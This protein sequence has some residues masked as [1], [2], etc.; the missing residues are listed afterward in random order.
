M[1]HCSF[2]HE[3]SGV[4]ITGD[5][6]FNWFDRMRWSYQLFCTDFPLAKQTAE[7]LGEADYEV[8]A[9]THG[10]EIRDA[11]REKVRTFLRTHR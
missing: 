4:L 3:P 11:A 7:R 2:L 8:V 6:L 9:F 5:S 10:R 1:G